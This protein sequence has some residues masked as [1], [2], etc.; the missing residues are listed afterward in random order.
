METLILFIVALGLAMDCFTLGI[1]NS[2]ISGLVKP[3]VPL[4]VAIAFTFAHLVF[5]FAGYW[6][7]GAIQSFFQGLE[8]WAAF[9]VLGIIGAKMIL[10]ARRKHPRTKVFDINEVRVI[11]VLSLATAMNAFLAGVALGLTHMPLYLAGL[12]VTV[13][14]FV[15]SLAGM[16][17]GGQLGIAYARRTA[18]FGGAFMLMAAAIFLSQS[19]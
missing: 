5:L 7:G 6:L 15:M 17:G 1:T 9:V 2:S 10:E 18:Y 13:S 16:A 3:G 4:K 11:V 12:L 8:A 19:I 14:V